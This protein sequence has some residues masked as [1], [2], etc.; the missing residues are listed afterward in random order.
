ML[1]IRP[2]FSYLL[3]KESLCNNV[4]TCLNSIRGIKTKGEYFKNFGYAHAEIYKGGIVT[5]E[6]LNQLDQVNN[7]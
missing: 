4:K 3:F 7:K 5:I 1:K 2:I 6:Y